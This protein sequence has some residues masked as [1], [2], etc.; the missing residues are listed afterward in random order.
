[1]PYPT[2]SKRMRDHML[3]PVEVRAAHVLSPILAAILLLTVAA[4]GSD[5]T[6]SV[7]AEWGGTQEGD[8][9]C[10]PDVPADKRAE[11][12]GTTVNAVAAPRSL[13]ELVDRSDMLLIGKVISERS[14]A[15]IVWAED[16]I[17]E[18][19]I[20]RIAVEETIKGR[21]EEN[22]EL[23]L[24]GGANEEPSEAIR[25]MVRGWHLEAGDRALIPMVH[26]DDGFE[27]PVGLEMFFKLCG[28]EV[29]DSNLSNSLRVEVEKLTESEVRASAIAAE[30]DN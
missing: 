24:A 5:S 18:T 26:G 21:T 11:A 19:R 30:R 29:V 15:P 2:P 25:G 28:G 20:L 27:R 23:R 9:T 17:V 12:G 22:V 1:M 8:T 16:E 7:V 6:E 13:E 4:C 10:P 14:G 3:T